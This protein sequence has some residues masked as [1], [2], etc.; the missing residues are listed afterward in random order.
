MKKKN[1]IELTLI[2][3]VKELRENEKT[4]QVLLS[5][6]LG[7]SSYGHVGNIESPK[8]PHKYTLQQIQKLSEHFK[9]P[10]YKFFIDKDFEDLAEKEEKLINQLIIKIIEYIG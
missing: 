7:M 1:E 9:Y 10:L 6:I 4:S 2:R 3:K 8:F 5:E